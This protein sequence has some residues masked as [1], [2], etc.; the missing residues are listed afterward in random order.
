MVQGCAYKPNHLCKDGLLALAAAENLTSYIEEIR[1]PCFTL[2]EL[3]SK[4]G[5]DEGDVAMLIVDAEGF[6][7]AIIEP[8]L[9]RPRFEPGFIQLEGMWIK[10]ERIVS[11]LKA[12]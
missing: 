9:D 6:D 2:A 12:R 8:M 3:L 4:T 5:T 11:K 10:S 7:A 1:V